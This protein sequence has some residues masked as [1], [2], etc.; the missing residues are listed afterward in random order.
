MYYCIEVV[1]CMLI[2]SDQMTVNIHPYHAA[3][4]L[5]LNQC[6]MGINNVLHIN[7]FNVN[8]LRSY[9][10]LLEQYVHLNN[11]AIQH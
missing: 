2:Q 7:N 6:R 10:M 3:T 8:D 4:I 1:F 5:D 9:V 11:L